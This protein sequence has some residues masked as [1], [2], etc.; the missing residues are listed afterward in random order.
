MLAT[1]N[2]HRNRTNYDCGELRINAWDANVFQPLHIVSDALR[3]GAADQLAT[4]RKAFVRSW[5]YFA[6][7][8]AVRFPFLPRQLFADFSF[9]LSFSSVGE[10]RGH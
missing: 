10:G 6:K 5:A 1:T 4:R 8:K 7:S 3:I 2:R 9:N